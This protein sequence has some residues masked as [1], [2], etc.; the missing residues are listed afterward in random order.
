MQHVLLTSPHDSY[1]LLIPA[2]VGMVV[3]G[4]IVSR[5]AS[6]PGQGPI[7][8]VKGLWLAGAGLVVLGVLPP[9]LNR[10]HIYG[11]LVP[12]A[13]TL[14]ILFGLGLGAVLIPCLVLIQEE[15]EEATRGKIFG[16]AFLAINL[17]IAVPLLLAGAVADV[18]GASDVVA[19]LGLALIVTGV[20]V[21]RL[22]WGV[23]PAGNPP[24]HPV[25]GA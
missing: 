15:T 25:T 9:I 20:V 11:A 8:V 4:A 19:A 6:A 13:I 18:V 2:T 12:L 21:W 7:T 16:G 14:A 24:P 10:L 3:A 5:R 22:A 23:A 1:I 17:A